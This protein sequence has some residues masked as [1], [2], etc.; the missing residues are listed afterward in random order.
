M[1]KF[2]I[3]R[4][5]YDTEKMRLI[6]HVQ[7]WYEFT[8]YMSKQLFGEGMGRTHRCELYRS[9]KGNWLLVHDNFGQAITE[10]EAKALLLRYDYAAYAKMYGDIEE[11]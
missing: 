7:K 11:A 5:L 10:K 4:K 3:N 2:V 1:A 6:G 8:D 9:E